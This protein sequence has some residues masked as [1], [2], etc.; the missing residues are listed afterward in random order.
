MK[1]LTAGRPADRLLDGVAARAC[2]FGHIHHRDAPAFT[3][4]FEDRDG[5]LR[6]VAEEN[7][8]TLDLALETLLLA[9]QAPQEKLDPRIPILLFRSYRALRSAKR[10]IIGFLVLLDNTFQ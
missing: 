2:R 8:L 4:Q 1:S 10:E 7:A 3:R 9:L 6:Q 5:Q